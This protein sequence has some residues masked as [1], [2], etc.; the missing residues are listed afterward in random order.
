MLNRDGV[1]TYFFRV[2][3]AQG[4]L[5]FLFLQNQGDHLSDIPQGFVNRLPLRVTAF[6]EGAFDDIKAVLAFFHKN[7]QLPSQDF[8]FANESHATNTA[9]S[10]KVGK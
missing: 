7:G 2:I 4:L 3:V 1:E 6:K 10:P 5:R 9:H 8:S